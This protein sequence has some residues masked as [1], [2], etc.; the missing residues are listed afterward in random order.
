MVRRMGD[1]K[2]ART[3]RDLARPFALL[4]VVAVFGIVGLS[5]LLAYTLN[6]NAV[7]TSEHLFRTAIAE[8]L[9]RLGD[10]AL[11]YGY[12]DAAVENIV[13]SHD[14]TWIRN[15]IDAY[16]YDT[17]GVTRVHVVNGANAPVLDFIEG[18]WVHGGDGL[19]GFGDTIAPLIASARDQ[20]MD[21]APIVR[22][23]VAKR[24]ETL[25]F[26][27]AVRMTTYSDEA[28]IGTDHVM[29]MTVR[30]DE[31]V[32]ADFGERY[33]LPG[34][35]LSATGPAAFQAGRAIRTADGASAG[36]FVWQPALP[37][38]AIL[39]EVLVGVAAIL[40]VMV[41]AGLWF[42]RQAHRVARTV[43]DARIEAD[44]ASA[45][46]TEFLRNVAHEVRTPINAIVGF[47][48]IMRRQMFGPLGNDRYTGYVEDIV[49]AGDH[50]LDLV[51][52]LLDLERVEAGEMRFQLEALSLEA[53]TREALAYVDGTASRRA[54][55]LSVDVAP[56]LP[57]V[58]A[59]R[60]V[61]RQMLLNLLGNAIKFTPQGGHVTCRLSAIDDGFVAIAV[62]DDGPGID[63]DRIAD[64]LRPFGQIRAEATEPGEI[65]RGSG[66]GL[67][68]TKKLA[69]ALGGDLTLESAVGA[70]TTA[71]LRLPR[72]N[73]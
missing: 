56:D 39:P 72:A 59:D 12:W 3:F 4:V 22:T 66:L 9:M 47:A 46:K 70:G 36:Y 62:A 20:P 21:D 14:P 52:D 7:E 50:V 71:H 32:I 49:H 19:S 35:R 33:I 44:R 15:N 8:R 24:G 34:L 69:E 10:L 29:I 43:E 16:L 67:S 64:V 18:L 61:L 54:L 38:S 23:G 57:A 17:L 40:L 5:S 11:E 68:I 25:H 65:V 13:E 42:Y 53:A 58:R 48:D 26:A 6:R 55:V 2:P 28:D 60:R 1:E 63:P 51:G 41:I 31:T 45:A 30:I 27:A 37:G 73:A